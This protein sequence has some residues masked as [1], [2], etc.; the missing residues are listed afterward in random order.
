MP[1]AQVIEK[2][3]LKKIRWTENGDVEET[4]E[5]KFFVQ[6]NPQSLKV[7]YSNQKAGGDQQGSSAIQFV[8]KG[9]TKLSVEL[10]F[11]TTVVLPGKEA[12]ADMPKDVRDLT[13][14][15]VAFI[16]PEPEE[17]SSEGGEEAQLVPPGLRFGWGTFTFEGVVDS[18]NETLDFFSP[19]GEPLRATVTLEMSRQD[20]IVR[21]VSK[22]P[23]TTAQHQ[24]QDGETAQ[25]AAAKAGRGNDWQGM[26]SPWDSGS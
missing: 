24:V 20:I 18:I 11:D 25:S 4:G 12:E 5:E 2:A 14:R 1:Q 3:Y 23:G 17:G 16:K 21:P 9:T 6:F 26:A 19:K 8:G 22:S 13:Q 10:L 7:A 15:V